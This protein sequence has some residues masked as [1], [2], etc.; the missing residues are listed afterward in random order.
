MKQYYEVTKFLFGTMHSTTTTSIRLCFA[1]L[2]MLEKQE[3]SSVH[4]GT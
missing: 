2:M 4:I 1:G 3:T